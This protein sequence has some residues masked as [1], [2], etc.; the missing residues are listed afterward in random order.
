MRKGVG[1]YVL[2][3]FLFFCGGCRGTRPH[4]F[5]SM[6]VS[7]KNRRGSWGG[8]QGGGGTGYCERVV[9]LVRAYVAPQSDE[10]KKV[11]QGVF[12]FYYYIFS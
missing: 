8:V 1:R 12:S 3:F 11:Q 5:L 10:G 4:E 7:T 2:S 6:L 9:P